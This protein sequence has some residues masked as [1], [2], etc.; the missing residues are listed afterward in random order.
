MATDMDLAEYRGATA[1][2][3]QD[4][5]ADLMQLW[6]SLQGNEPELI[7]DALLE[8]LPVIVEE[9]GTATAVLAAEWFESL[10]TA[11]W[12]TLAPPV[13]ESI[14]NG[15]LRREAG[16]LWTDTPDALADALAQDL[17]EWIQR[18]GRHTTQFSAQANDMGWV[19]VPRGAKTCSFCLTLASRS[20]GWLYTT[21]DRARYRRSDGEKYHPDCDCQVVPAHDGG[22]VPWDPDPFYEMY[23][24]AAQQAGTTS[25]LSAVLA[26]MRRMFPD[27]VND[28]VH[29]H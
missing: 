16:K 23:S 5:Q 24:A 14:V 8:Y 19:R 20:A 7:R 21:E 22:D 18:P 28:G 1:A 26:E 27:A 12:A 6:L 11:G 2:L 13:P 10:P 25:D 17:T 4:A 29:A 9:Y 3:V 15:T